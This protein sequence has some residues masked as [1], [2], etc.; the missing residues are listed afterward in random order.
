MA[1]GVPVT[2]G[3]VDAPGGTMQ[4]SGVA[5]GISA[6][7][8]HCHIGWPSIGRMNLPSPSMPERRSR[9]IPAYPARR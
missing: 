9:R 3:G 8:R 7:A 2:A 4:R 6:T 5:V 1:R